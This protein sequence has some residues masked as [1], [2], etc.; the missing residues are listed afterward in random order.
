M[1]LVGEAQ[2]ADAKTVGAI[3]A[4]IAKARAFDAGYEALH[5]KL[6]MSVKDCRKRMNARGG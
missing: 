3:V 6:M 5:K 4:H 1:A 2:R